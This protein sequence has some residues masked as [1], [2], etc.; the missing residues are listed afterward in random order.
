MRNLHE[1]V[2]SWKARAVSVPRNRWTF[3][4]FGLTPSKLVHRLTVRGRSPRVLSVSL[5]KAGTHLL[6]RALCLHPGLY[7]KLMPTVWPEALARRGGLPGLL[8][9]LSPGQI[10]I[11]HIPFRE[12]YREMLERSRTSTLFLVRDP[13]DIVVSQAHYAVKHRN[14][15]YHE[16]FARAP[17]L[18]GRIEIAIDGDAAA[19]LDSIA[20]RLDRYEGWLSGADLVVR[21]EDLVGP[22]G[23]GDRDAQHAILQDIYRHLGVESDPRLVER[24]CDRLFSSESP[25]FR[26]GAIGGWREHMDDELLGRFRT[27]VGNRRSRYGYGGW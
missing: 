4:R 15:P 21:F 16:S 26:A 9:T 25:T 14:H 5:P 11:A 23:G 19:G 2:A 10:A 24:V 20:Q 12:G 8:R 22:G 1:T 6:E 13:M 3:E 7:R 27:A 18:R 17:D